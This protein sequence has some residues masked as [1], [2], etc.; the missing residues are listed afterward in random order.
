MQ[1]EIL[2]VHD[3]FNGPLNGLCLYE[4]NKCWYKRTTDVQID[5]SESTE[6]SEYNIYKLTDNLLEQIEN[7][8]KEYCK[9]T[10]APVAHGDPHIIKRNTR[11]E[12]RTP[13][14]PKTSEEEIEV[15]RRSLLTVEKYEYKMNPM[16]ISGELI[17][18]IK[19][20]CF[21]N[22]YLPRRVERQ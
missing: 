5:S 4:G 8:H 10:G 1:A 11:V 19:Q 18:T 12:R 9:I 22:Y 17:A 21:S 20:K 13:T 7:E 2:W 15:Q 16:N 6:N 3:D 14:T